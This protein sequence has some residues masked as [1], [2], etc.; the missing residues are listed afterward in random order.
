MTGEH[1]IDLRCHPSKHSETVRT[2]QVLVR[3]TTGGDCQMTFRLEG[4]IRRIRVPAP[5][6]PRIATQLWRHTCFEAFIAVDGQTAYHEFNFAPSGEWAVYAFSEYRNGGP[7]VNET[8]RPH[9]AVR[10]TDSRFELD[11]HVRVDRLSAIH[12]QASLRIGLS[13]VIE[14]SD[15][16]SYWALRHPIDRPDFHNADGFALLLEPPAPER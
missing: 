16:L 1:W 15:G 7:L 9:I 13:A 14:A 12:P 11:S 2:I 5:S 8:L 4:D 10:C 3:R 6:T